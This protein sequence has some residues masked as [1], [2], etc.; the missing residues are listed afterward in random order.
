MH[1]KRVRRVFM[2]GWRDDMP[3]RVYLVTLTAPGN[4]AHHNPRTGEQCRCT[5]KGGVNPAEWN[6]GMTQHFSWFM[7]DMRRIFGAIEFGRGNEA[8]RR[9]LMHTHVLMRA[10][11]DLVRRRQVVRSLAMD[12]G[13]GHE[14]DVELV[15]PQSAGYVAKYVSK[16]NAVRDHV[17]WID[18]KTGELRIGAP[19]MRAW[20]CSRRWGLTMVAVKR[21]QAEWARAAAAGRPAHGGGDAGAAPGAGVGSTDASHSHRALDPNTGSYATRLARR[22]ERPM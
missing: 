22:S 15:G 4:R 14:C 10:H 19:R 12:W 18:R 11:A 3:E 7:T 1:R 13:F 8:Q 16:T 20:S 17:P 2:S 21:A 6:A 5:P 9:G